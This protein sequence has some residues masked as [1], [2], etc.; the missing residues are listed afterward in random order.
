MNASEAHD[1]LD[2]ILKSE[3][4]VPADPAFVAQVLQRLDAAHPVPHAPQTEALVGWPWGEALMWVSAIA[5]L[6]A[7]TPAMTQG[8]LAFSQ[9]PWSANVW[10]QGGFVAACLSMAVL[11]YGALDVAHVCMADAVG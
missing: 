3:A 9:A 10:S 6:L 11:V 8:W 7:F 4:P 1:W 2:D 5:L